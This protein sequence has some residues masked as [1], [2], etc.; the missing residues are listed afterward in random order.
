LGFVRCGRQ[1]GC[2]SYE[3]DREKKKKKKKEKGELA[4]RHYRV[5]DFLTLS[6]RQYR[7]TIKG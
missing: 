7:Q 6:E 4:R 2:R 3:R 1:Y 5:R